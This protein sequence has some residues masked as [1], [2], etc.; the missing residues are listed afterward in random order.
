M[1]DH[2]RARAAVITSAMLLDRALTAL[3]HC[4]H[5]DLRAMF[6][7]C[8]QRARRGRPAADARQP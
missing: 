5:R 8:Q 2:G 7:H 4:T 1:T 3:Q 6:A